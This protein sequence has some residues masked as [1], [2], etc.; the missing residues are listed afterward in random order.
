[1]LSRGLPCVTRTGSTAW[2]VAYNITD[3]RNAGA[4]HDAFHDTLTGL[5]NRALF[6]DRL[7]LAVERSKRKSDYQFAVLFL[8]LDQFKNVNDCLG[9]LLGDQMLV[10]VAQAISEVPRSSDTVARFGGDEFVILLRDIEG[11]DGGSRG[12]RSTG[13]Q[14]PSCFPAT[15]FIS[16]TGMVLNEGAAKP[17]Y[18]AMRISPCTAKGADGRRMKF[19]SRPYGQDLNGWRWRQ[20][21]DI[22]RKEFL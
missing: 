11:R 20:L 13:G 1:V 2:Q 21:H 7:R 18:T 6:M 17:R 19:S 14:N 5:P 3:R 8:D 10:A 22:R 16:C 15:V 12:G 9:H 4:D